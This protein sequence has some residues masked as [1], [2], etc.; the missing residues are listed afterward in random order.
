[1]RKLTGQVGIGQ[2]ELFPCWVLPFPSGRAAAEGSGPNGNPGGGWGE[3]EGVCPAWDGQEARQF[4]GG[5]GGGSGQPS[6]GEVVMGG[7]L[8]KDPVF[9]HL[10]KS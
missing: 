1:M 5:G 7:G 4:A 8:L 2:V 6:G 9:S 10:D 3:G